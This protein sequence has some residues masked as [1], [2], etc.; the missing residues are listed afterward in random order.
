MVRQ[1][2]A[3]CREG[4]CHSPW[5]PG[6]ASV[7]LGAARGMISTSG[8]PVAFEGVVECREFVRCGETRIGVGTRR[9]WSL[10]PFRLGWR[11]AELKKRPKGDPGKLA[12]AA[13]LRRETAL[14]IKEIAGQAHLGTSKSANARLHRWMKLSALEGKKAA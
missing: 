10:T 1:P 14:S 6:S 8:R 9:N 3:E 5:Q 11:K 12:L 4:V 7:G 13:R 2:R